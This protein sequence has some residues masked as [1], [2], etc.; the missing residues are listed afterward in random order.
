MFFILVA[1]LLF[2]LFA[3]KLFFKYAIGLIFL[4]TLFFFIRVFLL[5]HERKRV[6]NIINQRIKKKGYDK[7]IFTGKCVNICQ[8]S[9]AVYIALRYADKEELSFFWKE[10]RLRKTSYIHEDENLEKMLNKVKTHDLTP[11]NIIH[12]FEK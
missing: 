12:E 6:F 4:A 7:K 9:Q 10:F 11:G 1:Q 8:L 5:R 3:D 2:L